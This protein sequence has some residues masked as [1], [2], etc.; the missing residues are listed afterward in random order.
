MKSVKIERRTGQTERGWLIDGKLADG[1][2]NQAFQ[3]LRALGV[4]DMEGPITVIALSDSEKF[5]GALDDALGLLATCETLVAARAELAQ[6]REEL[7]QLREHIGD[8]GR[9][10]DQRRTE[11]EGERVVEVDT[12]GEM[13]IRDC[14]VIGKMVVG[15]LDGEGPE[16]TYA[17]RGLPD[18]LEPEKVRPYLIRPPDAPNGL[19]FCPLCHDSQAVDHTAECQTCGRLFGEPRDL[20]GEADDE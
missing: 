14:G 10:A 7:K 16:G 4:Y 12:F 9:L 17:I 5:K 19:L 3:I 1:T 6:M 20:P 2:T 8:M 13:R 15:L 18:K 11:R